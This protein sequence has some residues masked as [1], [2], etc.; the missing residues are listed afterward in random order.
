LHT[1]KP[2]VPE[3]PFS[4][5]GRRTS[6]FTFNINIYFPESDEEEAE[7][8]IE[9]IARVLG[10]LVEA[11]RP[12]VLEPSDVSLFSNIL[13]ML[14]TQENH[15]PNW[16]LFAQ[17]YLSEVLQGPWPELPQGDWQK[18]MDSLLGFRFHSRGGVIGVHIGTPS[19]YQTSMV[20][21][22]DLF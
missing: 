7:S 8:A 12:H 20:V 3:Q 16:L 19:N 1:D 18:D 21:T 11:C 13:R 4:C 5:S 22:P 10:I 15:I 6:R 17:K 9:R 2:F 14:E